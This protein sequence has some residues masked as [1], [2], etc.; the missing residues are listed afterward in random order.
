MTATP[1]PTRPPSSSEKILR[2]KFAETIAGQSEQMDKLGQQLIALELAIPGL[3]ATV[4][5]LMS[6]DKATVAVNNAF[7][8][9]FACWF[10]ALLL[11]LVSL[12]PRKWNVDPGIMK[13]DD[14]E[15]SATLGIEDFFLMTAQ[16][17]RRLLI[18][19]TL[20]FFIGVV[21]AAYTII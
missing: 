6:G 19:S 12:I 2:E 21:S 5:K 8:L 9:T 1:I 16:H 14:F 15:Q 11:S 10:F 7:Y 18:A 20:L 13:K 4:L 3:Y 17:K